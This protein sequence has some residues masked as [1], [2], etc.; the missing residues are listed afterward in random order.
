MSLKTRRRVRIRQSPR[1]PV[2]NGL[3]RIFDFTGALNVHRKSLPP[4]VSDRYALWSDWKAVGDDLRNV[5]GDHASG[6][7]SRH[8]HKS[9][10]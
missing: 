3:A 8:R 6:R 2:L 7:V 9:V 10:G 5:I 1:R 4:Q